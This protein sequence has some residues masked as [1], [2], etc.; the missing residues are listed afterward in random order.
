MTEDGNSSGEIIKIPPKLENW[1][2]AH[3][4]KI[5]EA[6]LGIAPLERKQKEFV[7]V[8]C[9]LKYLKFADHRFN[10]RR[11]DKR[12]VTDLAASISSLTLLTPLTC[13][14]LDS[15]DQ[16][17]DEEVVLLDGMHRF[18][19]LE[20]L[21]QYNPVWAEKVRIDLKIYFN[22]DKSDLYVLATY[23]NKTRKALAKGEY[24]KIIVNIFDEKSR[25]FAEKEGREPTEKEVF[26]AITARELTDKAFDLS[27][28]RIVGITAFDPEEEGSWYP[29]VG[30]KQQDRIERGDSERDYCPLTAGNLA[31]L[32]GHLCYRGP[33][34]DD[35]RN[36]A[37]E[38]TNVLTLGE[39]FTQHILSR[40]PIKNYERASGTT[41]ACKHWPLDS[42]GNLIESVWYQKLVD[43]SSNNSSLLSHTDLKWRRI[44]EL[45]KAYYE[46]MKEQAK[47]TNEFRKTKQRE[48][49][50]KMW[51]Y[52]TQTIQII[53]ELQKEMER[54]VDWL[55]G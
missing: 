28:G 48:M 4:G 20:Q 17:D 44:E 1:I 36:R 7:L 18:N 32:L 40:D 2:R 52:Q 24:Y 46:V 31:T 16:L 43:T 27:I 22:L 11:P 26:D 49:V 15:K 6:E 37:T 3:E 10:P 39:K 34:S 12:K 23:L 51:S 45:L 8:T 29:M 42:L 9:L 25:E 38:I 14:Y 50:K 47:Y 13:A 19:A 53:P 33:Y 41:V 30:L 21:K 54:K 5:S 35:G 55:R